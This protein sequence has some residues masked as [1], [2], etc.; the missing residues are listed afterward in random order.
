MAGGATLVLSAVVGA[1]AFGP[2]LGPIVALAGATT[3]GSIFILSGPFL[4]AHED[5]VEPGVGHEAR[6]VRR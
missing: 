2:V 4:M 1:V 5:S 6:M 3:V